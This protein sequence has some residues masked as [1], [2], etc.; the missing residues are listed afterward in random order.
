M[1]AIELVNA[2]C[3]RKTRGKCLVAA[4]AREKFILFSLLC[5]VFMAPAIAAPDYY[6]APKEQRDKAAHIAGQYR[7][8]AEQIPQEM[9]DVEGLADQLDYDLDAAADYVA[10]RVAFDPYHGI[11]RGPDGTLSASAG[12]AW[13]QAGLLVSLINTMGGDAMVVQGPLSK[14]EAQRLLGVAFA[15]RKPFKSPLDANAFLAAFDDALPADTLKTIQ[16]GGILAVDRADDASFEQQV[17]SISDKLLHTLNAKGVTVPKSAST[18]SLVAAL[19]ESYAWVRYRESPNEPWKEVHPAFGTQVAPTVEA[20]AYAKTHA[21]SEWVHYLSIELEIEQGIGSSYTSE[22]IIEPYRGSV[23]SFATHQTVLEI[24]PNRAPGPDGAQAAYFVPVIN[25]KLA[26]GAKAFTLLGMTAP[27]EAATGGPDIFATVAGKLGSALEGINSASGTAGNSPQLTGITLAIT[28][29]APGGATNTERRRLVDF[30]QGLP[31]DPSREILTS[32]VIDV[33][34]GMEN[35]AR[36]L[37]AV[38]LSNASLIPRIPY[39]AAL[40]SGEMKPEEVASH[41]AFERDYKQLTWKDM[42]TMGALLE[43]QPIASALVFRQS[44]LVVMTRLEAGLDRNARMIQ[45]V[46]IVHNSTMAL[47][48]EGGTVEIAPL[49]NL[50]QGVRETLAEGYLVGGD[51]QNT[52]MSSPL[53]AAISDSAAIEPWARQNGAL[54]ISTDRM[55]ADLQQAGLLL[56]SGFESEPRW[57][58]V[59]TLTGQTLGMGTFGGSDAT[60]KLAIGSVA[61]GVCGALTVGFFAYGALGCQE[62]YANKPSM[63]A[64]CLAGNTLLAAA[65]MGASRAASAQMLHILTASGALQSSVGFTMVAG[66]VVL[67]AQMTAVGL[68]VDPLCSKF[69]GN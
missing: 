35:G 24:G 5:C 69:T 49:L 18:D 63:L 31:V 33:G 20:V 41:P 47:Q 7:E 26:P 54:A 44:P 23:A 22:A 65:G 28:H 14:A 46:D 58:R 59:N 67:N 6:M 30:R 50:R 52:W 12:S 38:L 43:P 37:R 45:I 17:G 48:L 8:L 42:S 51:G 53:S 27:A 66:E 21:P 60:E 56:M 55:T 25:G 62:A 11:L 3:Q 10:R 32:A 68:V 13:D 64:C 15:E 57:W 1:S 2:S 61:Q 34:T 9:Y 36:E 19:S 16:T 4:T 40:S 29:T 39:V